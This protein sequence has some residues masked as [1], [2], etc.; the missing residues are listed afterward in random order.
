MLLARTPDASPPKRPSSSS[1]VACAM[2]T[3]RS[4]RASGSSLVG[5]E[6]AGWPRLGQSSSASSWA[7]SESS[8]ASSFSRPSSWTASGTPAES[9]PA[10]TA[11]AGQPVT[12]HAGVIGVSLGSRIS[13]LSVPRPWCS[14]IGSGDRASAGVRTT[15]K[16]SKIAPSR[17]LLSAS[18]RSMRSKSGP[19]TRRPRRARLRV[20]RSAR[21]RWG[22]AATSSA[23]RAEVADGPLVRDV[24][25][26]ELALLDVVPEVP[27][28]VRDALGCDAL[29]VTDAHVPEVRQHVRGVGDAQGRLRRG[30]GGLGERALGRRRAVA[31]PGPGPASTSRKRRGVGDRARQAAGHGEPVPVFGLGCER[32]AAALWLEP[33]EPAGGGRDP[34]RA[35]S[36]GGDGGPDQAGG[37]RGGRATARATGTVLAVPRIAGGPVGDGLDKGQDAQLGHARLADHHGARCPQPARQLGI[38][39]GGLVARPVGAIGRGLPGD[40]EAVLDRDRHPQ[41]RTVVALDPAGVGLVG[42]GQG[43]LGHDD[44]ERVEIRVVL[45][46]APEVEL[47]QLARGDLARP[48]HLG[49]VRDTREREL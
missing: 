46:D 9:S 20:R 12:F 11:A 44:P 23:I 22:R 26:V 47:G 24:P 42:L 4:S 38:L 16:S 37:H 30:R 33:D 6:N 3:A 31:I 39:V 29:L 28:H 18:A 8:V 34:D 17:R 19:E 40:V 5:L 35:Q 25:V 13:M 49:L 36:V 15:S 41:Q 27:Q 21:S 1:P 48:E 14:P 43:A 32:N 7:A 2:P 45:L 10:G